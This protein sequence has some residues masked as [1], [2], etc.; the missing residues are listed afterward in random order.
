MKWWIVPV[1][2]A[3]VAVVGV[4]GYGATVAFGDERWPFP[5]KRFYGCRKAW[6][7]RSA[8]AIV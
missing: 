7:R 4:A 6:R 1:A 3:G 2:A 5:W 8:R